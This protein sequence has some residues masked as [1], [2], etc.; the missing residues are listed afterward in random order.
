[1]LNF[2]FHNPT[3]IIFGKDTQKEIGAL[4]KPHATKI[5]LHYGGNSIK[6]SGL[7]DEVVASLKENN[8]D[9]IELGGVV[10][11]PRL[12]LVHEG[13]NLCKKEGVDLILD[14]R[15]GSKYLQEASHPGKLK[16]LAKR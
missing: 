4:L 3:R 8:L 14:N 7:Y 2:D 13:I 5:L 6:K 11:N 12:A 10:P 15:S 1:M 16:I 9:F